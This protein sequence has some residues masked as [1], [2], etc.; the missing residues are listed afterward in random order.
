MI[1]MVVRKYICFDR[2][3]IQDGVTAA[4]VQKKLGEKNDWVNM[5]EFSQ[6]YIKESY[7]LLKKSING[8]NYLYIS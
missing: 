6:Q 8:T 1:L 7:V 3:P 2:M 5:N 4:I